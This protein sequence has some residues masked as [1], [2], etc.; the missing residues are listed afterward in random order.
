MLYAMIRHDPDAAWT[1]D[2]RVHAGR[3]LTAA[4][5]DVPG[6]IS[7]ALVDAGGQGLV[8]IAICEDASALD[9][10]RRLLDRWLAEHLARAAG[11][12]AT[13]IAG[14]VVVQCGL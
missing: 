8:S 4:L 5:G 7:C 6:F 2:D 9:E 11:A 3:L 14:A 12:P 13:E 10:A 1:V